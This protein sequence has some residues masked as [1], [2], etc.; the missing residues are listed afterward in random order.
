[1]MARFVCPAARLDEL[2]GVMKSTTIPAPPLRVAVLGTGG[3]DPPSFAGALERDIESMDTFGAALGE[4]ALMDVFEVKLP[5][6]G[7]PAEAVDFVCDHLADPPGVS[8]LPFFEV[9]L[10]G[11]EVVQ[12]VGRAAGAVAAA[13]HE[14]DPHR[15][16]GLK[17]RCGGLDASA[18]PTVDAVA[19]AVT[20]C[21]DVSL[22]M[23]ATQ[24]LHHPV[25]HHDPVLD[26]T[27]HGFLNLFA[28]SLLAAAHRLDQA[29][30]G[31]IVA[32]EDPQAFTVTECELRWQ[33]L[34]ADTQHIAGG[35]Q[36]AI[37]SF[38]SCSFSEPRDDL[39][40]LGLL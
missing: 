12:R 37:T 21:R 15:R 19:A 26:T 34:S 5:A 13:S 11:D 9:S 31:E 38:G 7:E 36:T 27:I 18:V 10:L 1:M 40:E 35:R 2:A 6:R 32:E 25:R 4:T 8:L 39:R 30:I 16:A 24:G 17:I 23:K 33:D 28:A 22:P 20:A 14:I 29:T 3:D